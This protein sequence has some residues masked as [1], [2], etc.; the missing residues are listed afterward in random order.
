MYETGRGGLPKDDAQAVNWYRKAA[1]A[2]H[3]HGMTKLAEMYENGR[4]GLPEDDAEAA[5]WYRKAANTGDTDARK[6]LK[7]L[8]RRLS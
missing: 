7:R 4:G 6:A 1:D 3:A 8:M 2:G 5:N